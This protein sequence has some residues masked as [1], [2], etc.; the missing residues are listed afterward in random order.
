MAR[1]PTVGIGGE[2]LQVNQLSQA[3][4][5][6]LANKA[7]LLTYG[8]PKPAPPADFIPAHV[9]FDKKVL[10]F[11]AY[12][13]EDV[14]MSTE[15]HYR[16]RQVNIYYYLEDD[17]MSVIEPVVE[18]SGIPQGRLIKRQRLPK[19][20]QGDHYHWKDL[21]RGINITVYGKTFHIV[22]CD[23]FTQE[24]LES[25]GIELNPPEKMAL[26]PYTELRKQPLHQYVTPSDF[27]QL[28]QFLTFDKQVLRFYAIWDDTDSMFGE[29]RNYIIHYYLTDD[30][31]E[32][33]EVHERNDGRDPFP[34]LM[35][36][37]H[38]PKVLVENAKNFPQC[39][40]EISDQEVLEWYTAKDF[41][42]G[43]PLTI[44]GRTFF[45]Y[46]CDPF[47]RQYF[48]EKFGISDLPRIDM[49]KKEQ[50]PIKQVMEC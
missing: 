33:R 10:K 34:L 41:I 49:S 16:I 38:M 45:I 27:D 8:E 28:K 25:Q 35:N 6:E 44:L 12:F 11:E 46:D 39:V 9:A 17:S 32:I 24:F 15:E 14:P 20:D 19:N 4:L 1:R 22:E 30:T 47:T 7:P 50:P 48:K 2:R 26:D 40:L 37:Q 21:N 5:D 42:V 31:V 3:D 43:K 29:C 13:Q 36:R 23:R 18:N